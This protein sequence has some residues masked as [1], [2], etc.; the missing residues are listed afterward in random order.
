MIGFASLRKH[1]THSWEVSCIAV[2]RDHRGKGYGRALL[3]YAESWAVGQGAKLLQ[4]KTLAE[5]NPSSEY[6]QTRAFYTFMGYVPVEVFPTLWS[7]SNPCL[8][9]L[10]FVG[11]ANEEKAQ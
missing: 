3:E 10:K 11:S 8:Q 2:H 4:V 5:S 9:M 7:A 6:R 1:F